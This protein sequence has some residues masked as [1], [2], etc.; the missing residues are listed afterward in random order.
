MDGIHV[1]RA[2]HARPHRVPLPYE[3]SSSWNRSSLVSLD[4]KYERQAGSGTYDSPGDTVVSTSLKTLEI[5]KAR[6][7]L[8]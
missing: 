3:T 8:T 4:L 2:P 6:D 5:L 1:R 7:R